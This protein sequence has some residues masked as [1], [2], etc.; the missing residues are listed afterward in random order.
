MK[1]VIKRISILLILS[2]LSIGGILYFTVDASTLEALGRITPFYLII[3]LLSW[4]AV[5]TLDAGALILLLRGANVKLPIIPALISVFLRIF[6]NLITPFSFGGQPFI[7]VYLQK[8][9]V[10]PG[11]GATVV[12]TKL[13]IL[14]FINM[15]T[16]LIVLLFF[17]ARLTG[18]A[19]VNSA[20]YL[21]VFISAIF[22][23]ILCLGMLYPQFLIAMVSKIGDLLHRF[24]ILKDPEKMKHKVIHEAAGARRTFR[25]YFKTHRFEFFLSIIL[26][27]IMHFGQV[28]VLWFI[29]RGLGAADLTFTDG[30]V[31]SALL[32]F[33]I[34]YMPTPG[35]AGLGEGAFYLLFKGKVPDSIIGVTL[36]LWRLFYQYLAA[37][38]G[39]G[40][41][42]AQV[43]EVVAQDREQK[44]VK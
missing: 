32:H 5:R 2:A 14:S 35:S 42:A 6:Y 26:S 8:H 13:M 39:A 28:A 38:V 44:K 18:I 29:F 19:V 9:G 7:V 17:P 37:I 22:V 40:F 4:F 10:P 36:V 30:L 12:G 1:A 21:T 15:L 31:L 24:S 33:V 11:K 27:A 23:A 25:K 16:A 43:S 3:I 20:I 41:S 34:T